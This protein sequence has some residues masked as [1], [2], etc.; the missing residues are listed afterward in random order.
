MRLKL[1]IHALLALAL[2]SNVLHAQPAPFGFYGNAEFSPDFALIEQSDEQIRFTLDMSRLQPTGTVDLFQK[3]AGTWGDM[4]QNGHLMPRFTFY[5]Q[6]P[7]TG[8]PSVTVENLQTIARPAVARTIPENGAPQVELGGIGI[9]AGVRLLPVT[10]RPFAYTNGQTSCTVMSEVTIRIDFDQTTGVNPLTTNRSAFSESARQVFKSLVANWTSIPNI[11][12][13]EP[14]HILAFIPELYTEP[15]ADYILWKKQLGYEIS[16]IPV[17]E[18]DDDASG[19]ALRNRIIEVMST[20]SPRIDHVLLIGDENVIP[21]HDQYTDDPFTRFSDATYPGWFTNEGHY[22][23]L[24]GADVFPDVFL[25]RWVVNSVNEARS[26]M[27]RTLIHE[28]TPFIADSARFEHA[29]VAADF[30]EVS[31]KMTKQRARQMMLSSG[32]D[33]VDTLW[34][35]SSP[36]PQALINLL[37]EGLTFVNYRG[38]G[39]E[40]GWAGI[41]FYYW[42][43]PQI[44]NSGL[45]PIVTGIGCGVGKFDAP[46]GQCFG[47][48]WMAHGTA[49]NPK[50]AAGFIGPCWNTHTIYND[51]LDTCLYRA[52]LDYDI[53]NL[54]PALAAAK[55]YTWAVFNDFVD[56]GGVQEICRVMMRQYLVLS[57]PALKVYTQTPV[58]M[59]ITVPPAIPAGPVAIPITVTAGPQA[60]ADSMMV[61]FSTLS[62]TVHSGWIPTAPGQWWVNADFP[63]G[64]IVTAT[65]SGQNVLTQQWPIEVSP[66]GPYLT[67][68]GVSF[69]D[70]AGNANGRI[71][72]GETI[73]IIDTVRN[74]G[75][76]PANLATGDIGTV[77]DHVT[78]N[79]SA[80]QYGTVPSNGTAA[81]SPAFSVTIGPAFHD[82]ANIVLSIIYDADQVEPR[83][84]SMFLT[85]FVP[86]IA[87]SGFAIADGNN[88]LLE[89]YEE[90]G[91]S[92]VFWNTGNEPLP[93]S[94]LTFSTPSPYLVIV[95]GA[96]D[97]PALAPNSSYALPI[98]AVRIA[99]AWNAPSGAEVDLNAEITATMS[100]YTFSRTL[101][102]EF[103][104]G[105][106]GPGDPQTGSDGLYYLYDDT[107]MSYDRAPV[108]DWFEISPALGGPGAIMP[109]SQSD[110]TIPVLVPFSYSYFGT[111]YTDLSVSTDGW[112]APGNTTATSYANQA[113]P[114]SVDF[115]NGMIGILWNNLWDF[116]GEEG[117]I[118]YYY[119]AIGDRFV[120]EWHEITDWG[121]GTRPNTFQVHLLNPATHPTPTGDAEWLFMYQDL[122]FHQSAASGAT[123]GYENMEENAGATY[124]FDET[125]APTSAPLANGRAIRLSTAPPTIIASAPEPL[126]LPTEISLMQNYPNP[127]NPETTIEFTLPNRSNLTLEVFDVLGRNVATLAQGYFE[128]GLH[129]VH[130]N[131]RNSA[132]ISVP[133]GI[134]FC[135]LSA[136]SS[137][138]TRRMLLMR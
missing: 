40:Q 13:S 66:A 71:E 104:V 83:T 48:A 11:D 8:S 102:F 39:W 92:V 42:N 87:T 126:E 116:F 4:N 31:Q 57:D 117:D 121:T 96:A 81:S 129:S 103:T 18:I 65:V 3:Q 99:G 135:R 131:G 111:S 17:E 26:I 23:E 63:F 73:S 47:E 19:N 72:P 107:D 89:R 7:N 118:S 125:A 91:I 54:M 106:V 61:S 56:E 100:T 60:G 70:A 101:T 80:A 12:V 10:I 29:V 35:E 82:A 74:I 30:T 2:G 84:E 136:L 98:D 36:G 1:L 114:Q 44:D 122:T 93:A 27:T 109:F 16:V 95:D 123:I 137:V 59:A 62:G 37:S 133:S 68:Q 76:E 79:S 124:Y 134:Y 130:W 28:R 49:T 75:S 88:G 32:F 113:L 67:H 51:C 119:D 55:M 41:G 77:Q 45:L 33:E 14:S 43:V 6:V 127:F 132:G 86:D 46:D 38:S 112:V 85:V 22:T 138:Q 58:R 108:Y 110:Q 15:L 94:T 50:G 90:A 128:S 53:G 34:G 9:F 105:S 20:A 120:V 21:V 78:V 64:E 52:F 115:V 5:L 25:G 97:I 24:E 69:S